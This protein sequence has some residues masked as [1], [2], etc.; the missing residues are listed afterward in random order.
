[1]A[2]TAR[3]PNVGLTIVGRVR[4]VKREC[5]TRFQDS[6]EFAIE[7]GPVRD[8]HDH[9]LAP[10]NIRAAI[11][12]GQLSSRYWPARALLFKKLPRLAHN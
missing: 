8:V 5:P 4:I 6:A 9:M 11:L 7:P 1:M 3:T 2:G 10:D 12:E